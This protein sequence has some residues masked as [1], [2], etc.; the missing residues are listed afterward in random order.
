MPADAPFPATLLASS[1]TFNSPA[2]IELLRT[3]GRD[4]VIFDNAGPHGAAARRAPVRGSVV[5]ISA[6]RT[7]AAQG[8]SVRWM[9]LHR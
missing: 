8:V 9:R 6:R 7:P 4:V 3:G 1:P 5:Y 2:V